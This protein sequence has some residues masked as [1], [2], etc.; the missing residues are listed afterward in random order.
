[1][2][3]KGLPASWRKIP[4]RYNLIGDECKTCGERFF[5]PVTICPNCRRTGS[6][7]RYKFSGEGEIFSYTVVRAAQE[8]F[9]FQIPY[10][11]GIIKLKEGPLVISQIVDSD[12]EEIDIGK[13]VKTVFRK[14]REDGSD[15][16]IRYGYKFILD[17]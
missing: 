12:P 13:K 9:D 5:P 15:G 8:G 6:L 7:E 16:V 17:R 10:F 3:V 1:M 2:A 4:Q 11:L 14:V